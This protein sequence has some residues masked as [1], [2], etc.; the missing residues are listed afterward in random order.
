MAGRIWLQAGAKRVMPATFA[1]HEY[2]TPEALA[3]LAAPSSRP[4]TC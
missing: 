4:A 1:W 2:R 3:G